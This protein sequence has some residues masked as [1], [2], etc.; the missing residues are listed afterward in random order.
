MTTIGILLTIFSVILII[1]TIVEKM[2]LPNVPL[3]YSMLITIL[4]FF[5][6][7]QFL[8]LG[9][10]GEYIGKILKNVNK[11]DQYLVSSI[12]KKK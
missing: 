6:G 10:L 5:S 7:V 12:I 2:T 8:F 1:I 4:L 3:G 9:L 11:D